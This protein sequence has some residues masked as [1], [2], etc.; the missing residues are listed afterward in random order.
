MKKSTKCSVENK[1]PE[2]LK[3]KDEFTDSR[4]IPTDIQYLEF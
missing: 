2:K 3:I 1:F 4:F